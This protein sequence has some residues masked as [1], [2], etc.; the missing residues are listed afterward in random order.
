[1][2]VFVSVCVCLCSTEREVFDDY[3]ILFEERNRVL[4]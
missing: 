1:M 4:G 3:V 2:H